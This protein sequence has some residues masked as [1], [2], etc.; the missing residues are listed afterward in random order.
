ML[1]SLA[2]K[3]RAFG[4]DTLYS[5]GMDDEEMIRL[6]RSARR[7]LV[8]AD[9]GLAAASRR[10]RVPALLVEGGTDSERI[11]SMVAGARAEGVELRPGR[12]LCSLCNGPLLPVARESAATRVPPG[13]AKRHRQ[14]MECVACGK[15]YWKGGHWKK[16]RTLRRR[17]A[18]ETRKQG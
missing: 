1:G 4:F 10:G 17:F 14:F 8:T 12:P 9:R 16:L 2:R 11:G 18:P 5:R 6:A 13:V 3:L 7:V 15:M